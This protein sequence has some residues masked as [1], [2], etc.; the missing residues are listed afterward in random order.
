MLNHLPPCSVALNIGVHLT[1][2]NSSLLATKQSTPISDWS[3]LMLC[4]NSHILLLISHQVWEQILKI[5]SK[6]YCSLSQTWLICCKIW[7]TLEYV[8]SKFNHLNGKFNNYSQLRPCH[9]LKKIIYLQGLAIQLGNLCTAMKY[10]R[11]IILFIFWIIALLG[12][13]GNHRWSYLKLR[14]VGEELDLVLAKNLVIK[15]VRINDGCVK[16]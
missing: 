8:V 9:M 15:Q 7:M 4:F 12:P 14:Y 16:L 5:L 11:Y 10:L 3:S 13:E 2:R 6:G 1:Q